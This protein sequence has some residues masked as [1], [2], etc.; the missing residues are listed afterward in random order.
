MGRGEFVEDG[1]RRVHGQCEVAYWAEDGSG[2]VVVPVGEE[3]ALRRSTRA[4]AQ[5][6]DE[7]VVKYQ[8]G[9]YLERC[10]LLHEL[11]EIGSPLAIILVK[12]DDSLGGELPSKTGVED[13]GRSHEAR[14]L[15]EAEIPYP[16]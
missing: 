6:C 4:T 12:N 9:P 1:S 7:N 5:R 8:S 2:A 3:D 13:V 10:R 16:P 15:H 11:I 14:R